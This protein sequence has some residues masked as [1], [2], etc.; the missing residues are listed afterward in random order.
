MQKMLINFMK[1]IEFQNKIFE[2][3]SKNILKTMNYLNN[4][5]TN[6]TS[7]SGKMIIKLINNYE[8]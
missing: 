1:N 5:S 2:N 8:K 6:F 7:N 4:K 3:Y